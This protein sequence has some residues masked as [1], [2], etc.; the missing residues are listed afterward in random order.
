MKN[1]ATVTELNLRLAKVGAKGLTYREAL[2]EAL[3][4]GWI[5]GVRRAFDASTFIQRFSPRKPGAPYSQ[6]NKERLRYL[7]ARS[8]LTKAVRESVKDILAEKFKVASDIRKA[9]QADKQAWKNFRSF[10]EA[11]KRI[12][13]AFIEGA[14]NRPAEFEKRLRYFIKMTAANKQFGFGGIEKH[15]K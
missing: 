10:T 15:Y 1:H 3:C 13:V 6:A 8:K 5:D 4:F 11:Y 14:R 12:R 9:I 7:A 2:D